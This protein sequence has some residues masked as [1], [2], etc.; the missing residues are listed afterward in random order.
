MKNTNPK[1]TKRHLK[2]VL[3]SKTPRAL[4]KVLLEQFEE[5]GLGSAFL[6]DTNAMLL[7]LEH[8]GLGNWTVT[9]IY[10]SFQELLNKAHNE[11]R[12]DRR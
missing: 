8:L 4:P 10:E 9:E 5:D 2:K 6:F 11:R 12:K 1:M 7:N 3:V